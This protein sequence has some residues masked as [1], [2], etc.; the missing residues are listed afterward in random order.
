[1]EIWQWRARERQELADQVLDRIYAACTRLRRFP[2]LG[3][4]F[5]QI[6]PQAR[7]LSVDGYLALYR[8]DAEAV[9]IVRVIDQRRLLDDVEFSDE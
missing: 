1:L 9:T 6:A 3:P 4:P 5:A 7:K 2:Y 8:V